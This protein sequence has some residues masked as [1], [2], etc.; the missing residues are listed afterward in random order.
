MLNDKHYW[1]IKVKKVTTN[2]ANSGDAKS[3]AADQQRQCYGGSIANEGFNATRFYH[4]LIR[5]SMLTGQWLSRMGGARVTLQTEMKTAATVMTSVLMAGMICRADLY[6]DP[7]NGNDGNDGATAACAFRTLEKA[8]DT[9]RAKNLNREMAADLHVYLRGGVYRLDETFI[10]DARDSGSGGYDVVYQAYRDETPVICGG[11][12]ITG[13]KPVEGK[14]YYVASAPVTF[15]KRRGSEYFYGSGHG[16]GL[17]ADSF[18]LYFAQLYVSGVRAERARS[19]TPL[20]GTRDAWWDDPETPEWRDG[21]YVNQADIKTYTNPEDL[22]LLYLE[23]FKTFDTPVK[24]VLYP[25]GMTNEAVLVGTQ[26]DFNIGTSWNHINPRTA[27]FVVNAFEELDEP[28]EWYLNQKTRLVYYYPYQRD[29]DLTTAE[30]YAPRVEG[31]LRIDG[32]PQNR[33]RHIRIEGLTFQYGNWTEAQDTHLGVSQAEIFKNYSDQIPG[34]IVLEYADNVTVRGCTVRHMGSSGIDVY[35]A[36]SNILVEGNLTYDTTAAGIT[37]GTWYNNSEECPREEVCNDVVVRNNVV[38][39]TGR[40]YWQ[41]TGINVFNVYNCKIVHN[42]VSDTAYT[43]LH[44]RNGDSRAIN[45][46]IGKVNYEYNKVSR[47]FAGH[48][49]GIGDGAHFYLHGRYPDSLVAHNYSL[50]AN[51]NVNFEFYPDN[52]S[53]T[54]TF[55]KNVSR[56]SKAEFNFRSWHH[57]ATDIVFDGNYSDRPVENA[58]RAKLINHHL[59]EDGQWPPE[60]LKVMDEA[61]VEPEWEYQLNKT[62]SHDNLA[63]GKPCW[64]SS[65]YSDQHTAEKG[66]DGDWDTFWST[67]ASG[68]GQGWWV[69]DLEQPYVIQKITLLPRQKGDQE[70]AR[71]N[72]EVQASNDKTFE[73]YFVLAEQNEVPWYDKKSERASNLWEKFINID[74]AYRYLRVKASNDSGSFN[75]AEFGAYGTVHFPGAG[76]RARTSSSGSN[77]QPPN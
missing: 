1:N 58:G 39:N 77:N 70:F 73:T 72:V 71:C 3:G 31:L 51:R 75:F 61:G 4:C 16:R 76:S 5:G 6:V 69:V 66:N 17:S 28:G 47:A 24:T 45:P 52:W 10:L 38:R 11:R 30:V 62:Y 18:A 2:E 9:I 20:I 32:S 35:K 34:Q 7:V 26:P 63:Q 56:F 57:G 14:P 23:L 41:A 15:V 25:E 48:K 33:I 64:A 21:V 37:V 55:T 12:R 36:C 29:G 67:K 53:H 44:A 46:H 42:D 8:R 74:Q 40:D 22:R 60:A 50:Y 68:D 43:A 54:V 59:V 13:W 65:V 19:H 27:F 49:F